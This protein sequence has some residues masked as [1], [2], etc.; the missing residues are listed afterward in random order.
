MDRAP[1]G[2]IV[3]VVREAARSVPGVVE[4]E[5]CFIRKM[6]LSFY[7]DLHVGV[8]G[9]IS[10]RNGHRIAHAVKRTIQESDKRIADVLVHV[11]PTER[12][13]STSSV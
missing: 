6:G 4:V 12:N 7:V 10:V 9:N 11:E 13:S 8:D 1:R 3:T 2:Q 5:K